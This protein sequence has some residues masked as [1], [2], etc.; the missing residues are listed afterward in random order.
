MLY[1]GVATLDVSEFNVKEG[2]VI[3]AEMWVAN[4]EE[5]SL[6]NCNVVQAGWTVSQFVLVGDKYFTFGLLIAG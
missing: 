1:G 3:S 4:F 2:Q 6:D 5:Y